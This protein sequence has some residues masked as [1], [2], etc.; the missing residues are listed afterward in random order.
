[1]AR[2]W[3]YHEAAKATLPMESSTNFISN[4]LLGCSLQTLCDLR[5][6][7]GSHTSCKNA[8]WEKRVSKNYHQVL[9]SSRAIRPTHPASHCRPYP[10]VSG[11]CQAEP[12]RCLKEGVCRALCVAQAW[13]AARLAGLPEARP[14]APTAQPHD[15]A[16]LVLPQPRRLSSSSSGR[17]MMGA[18]PQLCWAPPWVTHKPLSST[19]PQFP[20]LEKGRGQEGRP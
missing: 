1:M 14:P 13:R 3:T 10:T 9:L 16:C 7:P 15:W 2:L 4:T 19:Q 8:S 6:G 12:R 5:A 18:S 17:G 11:K 20:H